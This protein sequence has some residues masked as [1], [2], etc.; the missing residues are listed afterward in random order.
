MFRAWLLLPLLLTTCR[1]SQPSRFDFV[2]DLGIAVETSDSNCID[3]PNGTLSIGQH[4][5]FV[6]TSRPQKSGEAEI[7]RKTDKACTKTDQDKPGLY[8]YEFKALQGAMQKYV[9]AIVIT[10]FDG[11]F[12]EEPAGIAADLEGNGK[13]NFFRSCTSSEGV[14]LTIWQG[15]PLEG[16]RKWHY[17]YYLGYDVEPS[18]TERDTQP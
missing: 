2:R 6:A 9:P 4:V 16:I 7:I 8:H 10:N 14:H 3:I 13:L 15:K 1:G 18:C 17:Y 5:R 12:R 11:A